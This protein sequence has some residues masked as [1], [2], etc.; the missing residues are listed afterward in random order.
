MASGRPVIAFGR[1]GAVETVVPGLSGVFFGE[2]TIEAISSAVKALAGLEID[3]H[4]I[5]E[6]AQQ[7]GREQFF[8]KMREH[9]D[10]LLE[11]KHSRHRPNER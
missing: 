1:G 4:K 11:E 2:Q 8:R 7:F 10:R 5:A 9:I 6:H 3:P